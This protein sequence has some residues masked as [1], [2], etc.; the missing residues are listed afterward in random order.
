VITT[1]QG[2]LAIDSVTFDCDGIEAMRPSVLSGCWQ[3]LANDCPAKYLY[4]SALWIYPLFCL[5]SPAQMPSHR[6]CQI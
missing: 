5:N 1:S 3:V 4:L 2:T 6:P